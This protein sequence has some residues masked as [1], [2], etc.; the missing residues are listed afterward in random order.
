VLS[1]DQCEVNAVPPLWQSV[2]GVP[3]IERHHRFFISCHLA[4]AVS[5]LLSPMP[6]LIIAHLVLIPHAISPAYSP[7]LINLQYGAWKHLP[8]TE[9]GCDLQKQHFSDIYDI[10]YCTQQRQDLMRRMTTLPLVVQH[11][12]VEL[13]ITGNLTHLSSPIYSRFNHIPLISPTLLMSLQ[14]DMGH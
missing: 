11:H 7:S 12:L 13:D 10:A 8:M 2:R 5:H 9:A 6:S 3:E 4:R 1:E 14:P